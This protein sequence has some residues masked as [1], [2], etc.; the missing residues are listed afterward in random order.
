MPSS[1]KRGLKVAKGRRY[2][3]VVLQ[4][5]LLN[6]SDLN[7]HEAL[8]LFSWWK[9]MWYSYE[10]DALFIA[11]VYTWFAWESVRMWGQSQPPFCSVNLRWRWSKSVN[12]V[13]ELKV[14]RD[15]LK[16]RRVE[17]KE[18]IRTFDQARVNWATNRGAILP[19]ESTRLHCYGLIKWPMLSPKSK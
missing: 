12:G 19:P 7:I 18:P 16:Q 17:R 3:D 15:H 2:S 14:A 1:S 8:T 6:G 13:L 4:H 10:L 9:W 11:I 5:L